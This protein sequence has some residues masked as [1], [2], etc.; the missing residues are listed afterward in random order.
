[1]ESTLRHAD[2]QRQDVLSQY[3][4]QIRQIISSFAEGVC[5]R[6]SNGEAGVLLV[7]STSRGELSYTGV[8]GTLRLFSDL[9]FIIASDGIDGLG[10]AAIKSL[11]EDL[12]RASG[13]GGLFKIDFTII[14]WRKIPKLNRT[15]FLFESRSKGV[16]LGQL[17][18]SD[19]L[20]RVTIENINWRELNE[21]F[22]HRM[23]AIVAGVPSGL[24]G[25][26]A[27]DLQSFAMLL[28]KNSLD[29]TTW[30]HPYLTRSLTAGFTGRL[31][32]LAEMPE[33]KIEAALGGAGIRHLQR[34]LALRRNPNGA[35]DIEEML[36]ST[37]E[38][39][40]SA[41]RFAVE[42]N[43][44]RDGGVGAAMNS[45]R[46]FDE[47]RPGPRVRSLLAWRRCVSMLGVRGGVK[48]LLL[49]WKGR[50]AIACLYL[51]ASL[52]SH[53]CRDGNELSW[54][55]KARLKAR[56]FT[57]LEVVE[58]SDFSNA[59]LDVQRRLVGVKS[60]CS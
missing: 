45:I 15:F 3:P 44:V 11:A 48:T 6:D 21:V 43:R 31:N 23:A 56:G 20:P 10:K 52:R 18:V 39:Y 7:G 5:A 46:L 4:E 17:P 9:E 27:Y 14:P 12:R 2:T 38:L 19:R 41:L 53:V 16:D 26:G 33:S 22:L 49:P 51:L 24:L 47:Y 59:W 57:S 30:L 55:N 58:P 8:N 50:Y 42:E 29:V 37:T 25:G 36:N 40:F 54:L 1:M 28:A 32:E 35:V 34:C 60:L 13:F